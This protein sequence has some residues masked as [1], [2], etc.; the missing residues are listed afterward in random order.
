MVHLSTRDLV[1]NPK[2]L[3]FV[4][5]DQQMLLRT[6]DDVDVGFLFGST[7]IQNGLTLSRD[8]LAIEQSEG[9][10]Y[11]GI[12]GT[13]PELLNTPKMLALQRAYHSDRMKAL[14]GARFAADPSALVFLW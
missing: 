3:Q 10:P 11:K 5:V 13:R 14:L 1:D 6:L 7:A 2:R 9:N 8:A 12:I 4:E